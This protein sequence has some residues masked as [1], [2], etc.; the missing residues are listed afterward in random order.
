[1]GKRQPP[2]PQRAA[3]FLFSAAVFPIPTQRIPAR[4]ELRTDLVGT[5]GFQGNGDKTV[6]RTGCKRAIG[7]PRFLRSFAQTVHD[8][9]LTRQPV[10]KQQIGH[11]PLRR[12]RRMFANGKIHLLLAVFLH[13][14]TQLSGHLPAQGKQ[15]HSAADPVKPVNQSD[16]GQ[17]QLLLQKI[18]HYPVAPGRCR[19]FLRKNA[20]RFDREQKV[21][22]PVKH[23]NHCRLPPVRTDCMPAGFPRSP[24]VTHCRSEFLLPAKVTGNFCL[25]DKR[26]R[27]RSNSRFSPLRCPFPIP[28]PAS[29]L[30]PSRRRSR[31]WR[32][33]RRALPFLPHKSGPVRRM[34]TRTRSENSTE[35]AT[36]CPVY[37]TSSKSR[38]RKPILS[39]AYS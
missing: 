1:M 36:E 19:G 29:F 7:E 35:A 11:A 37:C 24:P 25:R 18:G 27:N 8:I 5:P 30:P 9:A 6:R 20:D 3:A 32:R 4:G 12:L 2:R 34:H 15:H 14:R 10:K 22:V 13:H 31:A 39:R 28:A 21:P 16:I 17:V 23:F 33:C 26:S 38:S